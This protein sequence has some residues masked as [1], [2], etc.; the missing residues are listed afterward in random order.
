[1]RTSKSNDFT[2]KS[3]RQLENEIADRILE[4]A[5]RT[6]SDGFKISIRQH[7]SWRVPETPEEFEIV[8]QALV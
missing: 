6:H 2:Y 7:P 4:L 8:F 3:N 5:L 1:M